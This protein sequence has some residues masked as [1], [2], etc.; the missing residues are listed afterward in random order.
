MSGPQELPVAALVPEVLAQLKGSKLVLQAPPGAGK[1][2][3]LPLALLQ[4]GDWQGRRILLLQPRR[5]AAVAIAHY[6]AEQLGESVGQRVGYHVRGER[7]A[8][9]NTQLMVITEGI[10]VQYL[11]QDPELSDVAV[12]LFDEFH[13]RNLFSDLG[14][15][16]LLEALPLRP[17]LGVL[18]MS[19]TLPAETIASWLGEDARVLQS[20]GR[21]HPISVHYRPPKVANDWLQHSVQVIS[22]ALQSAAQGVLVFLPGWR[23][24]QQLQQRLQLPAEVLPLH[25][26]LPLAAQRAALGELP[27]GQKKVVLATNI[28]ETSLTIPGIDVVV[29]SGRER[30]SVFHPR[31]GVSRLQTQRISKAAA[32]QRA[33]RAGRLGPGQCFRLWSQNEEHSMRDYDKPALLT[34]DLSGAALE[35]KR[36]GTE[37][38]EMQFLSPANPVHVEVAQQHLQ[39]LGVVD[40]TLHLT[41]LGKRV[42]EYGAEPRLARI[43]VAV[44]QA[45]A[46][47][48]G[49]AALVLAQLEQPPRQPEQFPLTA[50]QLQGEARKRWQFWCQ[51]LRVKPVVTQVAAPL[52]A[53]LALW[54]FADRI[55]QCRGEAGTHYRLAYGG[56]AR[57]HHGD[58]RVGGE[59]LLVLTMNFSEAQADAIIG[60]VLPLAESDFRHPALTLAW[61]QELRLS[62]PRQRFEVVEVQRLGVLTVAQRAAQTQPTHDERVQL[63]VDYVQQQPSAALDWDSAASLLARLRLAQRYLPESEHGHWPDFEQR[64][65]LAELAHW[66]APYW[67]NIKDLEQLRRWSPQAALKARLSY[68][69][70]QLLEHLCPQYW[71]APSG[72]RHAIDYTSTPPKVALKLQEVFGTPASPAVCQGKVTLML[73]LL[74]PAGRPLQRTSDLASFWQNSYQQ[75]KK[76][77]KGRYPKHPWPDDPVQAQATRKTKKFLQNNE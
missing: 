33:G 46:E 11:Q 38:S 7:R 29:D 48:R 68:Q 25:R 13:E 67:Q 22:E 57:F 47:Q 15:A 56:G 34:D 37:L 71:H 73:E 60:C 32:T 17:D 16:M 26:Q 10:F 55:A 54:G 28:A 44:E 74:S 49:A 58:H 6:L 43:A 41:A 62:G 30:R 39:A 9:A 20:A 50:N 8:Q 45:S 18:I 27:E 65:L 42:A 59:W 3:Y 63:L 35:A 75:V 66:A 31:H 4:Q 24:I 21:Q 19:A 70:E 2:T 69:Q 23:E 72:H 64:A 40:G 12:V 14:L 1:S 53:E 5:L 76:E 36:W 77:M 61:Q 51:K 52:A